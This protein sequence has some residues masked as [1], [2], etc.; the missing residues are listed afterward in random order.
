VERVEDALIESIKDQ[1]S[2]ARAAIREVAMWMRE[3]EVG[4][5]AARWLEQEANQ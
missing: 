3:N 1:G 2:M 4:Y 5:T